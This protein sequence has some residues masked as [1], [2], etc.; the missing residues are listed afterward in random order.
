MLCSN[1]ASIDLKH[2]YGPL[3]TNLRVPLNERHT[4]SP[5]ILHY[6]S[7][8][9]IIAAAGSCELCALVVKGFAEPLRIPPFDAQPTYR[10]ISRAGNEEPLF[11][12][13]PRRLTKLGFGGG[14]YFGKSFDWDGFDF[15]E[16]ELYVEEGKAILVSEGEILSK[17]AHY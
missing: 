5:R 9:G 4:F 16:V 8:D 14:E 1:C 3:P 12:D 7:Y 10:A 2:V 17:S 13:Q 15:C 11:P 6:E